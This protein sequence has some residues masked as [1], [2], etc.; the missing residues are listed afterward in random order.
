MDNFD[1][2]YEEEIM[3]INEGAFK[4]LATASALGIGALAG[5]NNGAKEYNQT[6]AVQPRANDDFIIN[7]TLHAN[8]LPVIL[9]L[10]HLYYY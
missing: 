7:K 8:F 3:R 6:P 1:K 5:A 2:L 4:S 10:V 9:V